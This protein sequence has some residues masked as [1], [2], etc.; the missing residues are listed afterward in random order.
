MNCNGSCEQRRRA[1][2]RE[3]TRMHFMTVVVMHSCSSWR[4]QKKR[5]EH[6][7]CAECRRH[8]KRPK[9]Q[10]G[11]TDSHSEPA[12]MPHAQEAIEAE[13]KQENGRTNCPGTMRK[14]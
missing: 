6:Q 7:S 2:I 4:G 1:K 13:G 10:I 8:D 14:V 3:R 9:R 12:R 5:D 11:E